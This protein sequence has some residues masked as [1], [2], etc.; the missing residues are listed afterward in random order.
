M[1]PEVTAAAL[2]SQKAYKRNMILHNAV[3]AANRLATN[4]TLASADRAA[5]AAALADFIE[6]APKVE[7]PG[8]VPDELLDAMKEVQATLAAGVSE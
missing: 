5:L 2:R 8:P 7:D 6:S 3:K 4:K 1:T